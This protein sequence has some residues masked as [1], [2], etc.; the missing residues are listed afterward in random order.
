MALTAATKERSADLPQGHPRPWLVLNLA[1][2]RNRRFSAA[3]GPLALGVFGLFGAL[4]I[5]T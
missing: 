2:F 5:Q 4:F 1:F 3:A